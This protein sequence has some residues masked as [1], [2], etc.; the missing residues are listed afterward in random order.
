MIDE[1]FYRYS[2]KLSQIRTDE[3]KIAWLEGRI[4]QVLIKPIEELK[5]IW[6]DNPEIRSLN[7]GVMTL[8]CCGIEAL[9]NFYLQKGESGKKFK[10][11][12]ERY[13][14]SEFRKKDP[15]G[16][17]YSSI[18]WDEF[19]CGLTHSFSIEKGGI[20]EGTSQYVR[21]DDTKG[22]GIDLWCFFDDVKKA[23]SSYMLDVKREQQTNIVRQNFLIR[24]NL[25]FCNR[26]KQ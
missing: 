24:F 5:K 10:K 19:R 15:L 6:H 14:S 13:M 11:F 26:E 25:L 21:F 2:E 9:S 7:L 17:K 3:E 8:L 16:K 22:L 1:S 4:N 20:L 23:I 18:L 12:I